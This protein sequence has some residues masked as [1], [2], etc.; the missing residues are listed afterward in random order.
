M[1][2]SSPAEKFAGSITRERVA[3]DREC[4]I[5]GIRGIDCPDFSSDCPEWAVSVSDNRVT[6]DISGR[7]EDKGR[8]YRYQLREHYMV[9]IDFQGKAYY[10]YCPD[11]VRLVDTYSKEVAVVPPYNH[12]LDE[13]SP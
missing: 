10:H 6:I 5:T 3:F 2:C 8:V 7:F 4:L 9:G 13:M 12:I 1:G 11:T